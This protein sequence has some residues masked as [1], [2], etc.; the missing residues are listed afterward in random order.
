MPAARNRA[1]AVASRSATLSASTRLAAVSGSPEMAYRSFTASGIPHTSGAS[2][3]WWSRRRSA[4]AARSRANSGYTR[5]Q[6]LIA[7]GAPSSDGGPPLRSSMRFR[8]ASVSS[9]ADSSRLRNSAAA[10]SNPRSAGSTTRP[11]LSPRSVAE[12]CR[13]VGPDPLPQRRG[14][15]QARARNDRGLVEAARVEA[16][17]AQQ[18]LAAPLLEL[19]EQ[20]RHRWRARRLDCRRVARQAEPHR[21]LGRE[22]R[23]RSTLL[24]SRGR[25]Q[26]GDRHPVGILMA[27]REV[28]DHLVAHRS[29]LRLL[30]RRTNPTHIVGFVPPVPLSG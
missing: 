25:H 16:D 28:D 11:N 5:A 30:I 19:L 8:Q 3:R 24:E 21:L 4:A 20:P 10:S 12:D 1:Q 22:H 29:A 2:S 15:G 26:E 9:R 18:Q 7:S 6:A 14:A 27:R 23:D 13:G 17:G